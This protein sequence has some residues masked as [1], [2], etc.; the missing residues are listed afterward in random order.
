MNINLSS[1]PRF[2]AGAYGAMVA[3]DSGE[4]VKV[5][6]LEANIET[7][8]LQCWPS[9][10]SYTYR[11]DIH[12]P[13]IEVRIDGLWRTATEEEHGQIKINVLANRYADR[14]VLCCDSALVDDLIRQA[15]EMRGD[16][17][18]GFE[19][20]SLR[21]LYADPSNWDAEECRS[22]AEEHGLELPDVPTIDC[23]AC[24]E[25]IDSPAGWQCE[26]CKGTAEVP[27]PDADE[28]EGRHGWLT[29]ARDVCREY[30]QENPAEV[31]EWWRVSS[32]L[33]AALDSIGEVTID[34][35]YGYWWGRCCTGQGFIMDGTLQK[36]AAR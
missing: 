20:E 19:Y 17:S 7:H 12:A 30:A 14:D 29:E 10:H 23:P 27:D 22:Y 36:V 16:I 21:N 24:I 6:D 33:C 26:T 2:R 18:D 35:G 4:F 13:T 32:W 28:D 34:N 9:G 31:Y 11:G 25:V 5:A 8:S 1:V 15:G 3:D